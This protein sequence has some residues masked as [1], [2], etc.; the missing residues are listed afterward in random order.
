[1][2]QAARCDIGAATLHFAEEHMS[3]PTDYKPGHMDVARHRDMYQL[4]NVLL[5]WGGLAVATILIFLVLLLCVHAGFLP[6][7]IVAV[8]VCGAGVF[9]LSRPKAH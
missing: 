5:N 4:F 8:V 2:S 7:A 9:W 6:S 3:Q 1:M